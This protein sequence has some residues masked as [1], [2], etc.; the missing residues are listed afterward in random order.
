MVSNVGW[1]E[2]RLRSISNGKTQE[3]CWVSLRSTQPTFLGVSVY[4]YCQE[5][6]AQLPTHL[7][8]NSLDAEVVSAIKRT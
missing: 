7:I 8:Q 4:Y 5:F 6:H 1:V 3:L 2:G